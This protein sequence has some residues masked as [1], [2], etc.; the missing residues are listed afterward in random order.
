MGP[1]GIY[2]M[3][4]SEKDGLGGIM[5]LPKGMEQVPSHWG[6]YI[7]VDDVDEAAKK[8][9]SLGG[10]VV[11][12]PF[13]LP[14]TGRTAVVHD[15]A[16]AHFYIFTAKESYDMPDTHPGLV[17]WNELM[18]TDVDKATTFYHELLGWNKNGRDMG[19]Q[20]TYW[21]MLDGERMAAGA[22]QMPEELKAPSYWLSYFVV[23]SIPDT[24]SK[25]QELGATVHVPPTKV[26]EMDVHFAVLAS[27]DGATFGIVE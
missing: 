26:E 11:R 6:V 16:G 14:D 13:D 7:S 22:V 19:D 27:P 4:S 12:E 2:T 23:E 3:L 17:G 1:A 5:D 8:V 15:P 20:G 21:I 18:S 10:A 24:V 25:A 9:V